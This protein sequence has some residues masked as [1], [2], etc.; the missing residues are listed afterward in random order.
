MR[1]DGRCDVPAETKSHREIGSSSTTAWI[2]FEVLSCPSGPA[3]CTSVE[4]LAMDYKLEI[5]VMRRVRDCAKTMWAS[6]T[7][8]QAD[9]IKETRDL[10]TKYTLEEEKMSGH[11]HQK[12]TEQEY[13]KATLTVV[14]Y[15]RR[16][17]G[18]RR[19]C[20]YTGE[21]II[22]N[23]PNQSGRTTQIAKMIYRDI[24]TVHVGLQSTVQYPVQY[25]T[26]VQFQSIEGYLGNATHKLMGAGGTMY[27]QH[28]FSYEL[29]THLRCSRTCRWSHRHR[30]NQSHIQPSC[31]RLHTRG[32]HSL[33][34]TEPRCTRR[35][36]AHQHS[37][38]RSDRRRNQCRTW[39][40]CNLKRRWRQSSERCTQCPCTRHRSL[41]RCTQL[42]IRLHR[43][44]THTRPRCSRHHIDPRR[45]CLHSLRRCSRCRTCRRNSRR[46]SWL[47][48]NQDRTLARSRTR[49]SLQRYTPCGTLRRRPGRWTHRTLVG[50]LVLQTA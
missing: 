44:S 16:W 41:P 43:M 27:F 15:L 38:P 19:G 34:H 35:R 45:N 42:R 30:C 2:Y 28:F 17:G 3:M 4:L 46:R 14:C 8:T 32:Q 10:V 25:R 47:R 37:P 49:H 1:P 12:K 22:S 20:L 48:Y 13:K 5:G 50:A 7:V 21:A 6:V 18:R 9:T 23:N 29:G 33:Q 24:G 11:S 26:V 39:T 31:S 40:P 36:S